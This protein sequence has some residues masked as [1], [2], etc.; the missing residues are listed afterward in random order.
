MGPNIGHSCL[1]RALVEEGYASQAELT[2]YRGCRDYND[3]RDLIANKD[4]SVNLYFGPKA[5]KGKEKNWVQT[6]PG[7]GWFTILRLYGPLEP[8]FD[9]TWKPGDFELVK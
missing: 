2:R 6:V 1:L 3:F 8:W 9:K 7:K 4:G 5:P